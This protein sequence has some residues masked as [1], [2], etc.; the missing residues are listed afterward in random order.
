MTLGLDTSIVLR[1]LTGEPEALARAATRRLEQAVADQETVIVTDLVAA[2]VYHALQHHYRMPEVEARALLRRLLASGVVHLD[3][4]GALAAFEPAGGA[5]LLDRL[6]HARH[7]EA[8]AATLTFDKRQ[9]RLPGALLLG[10][11]VS[12]R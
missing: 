12:D 6:I 8:G 4:S 10:S 3:P 2:E 7:Q 1:L 11:D 9:A 5:G